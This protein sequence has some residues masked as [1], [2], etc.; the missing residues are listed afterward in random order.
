M[1]VLHLEIALDVALSL[2]IDLFVLAQQILYRSY[3]VRLFLK[4][5]LKF[6]LRLFVLH[7]LFLNQLQSFLLCGCASR[8]V[9]QLLNHALLQHQRMDLIVKMHIS[10]IICILQHLDASLHPKHSTI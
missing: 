2:D 9:V 4:I 7:L 6:I 3:R 5:E 1:V 8:K 10:L